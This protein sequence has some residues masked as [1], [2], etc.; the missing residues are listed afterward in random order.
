MQRLD[1]SQLQC[2]QPV[3]ETRKQLQ[4]QPTSP[5]EVLVGD[6]TACANV[7][8]LAAKQG[9]QAQ[10][11]AQN[12]GTFLLHLQPQQAETTAPQTEPGNTAT[13]PAPKAGPT[14]VYLPSTTMGQGSEELGELLMRNFL[15]T[16]AQNSSLPQAILCVNS[17]VKLAVTGS[18]TLEPLQSL[19][20]QGVDIAA[21]GLCLEFFELQD[22]LAIGRATNMVET[23]ETLMQ[24]GHVITP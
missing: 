19:A 24:A 1:L 22:Q 4:Q 11:E 21:C 3:L 9:F 7:A 5:V 8:R 18:P 12:D 6:E 2:P 13:T 10:A 20:D 23:V 15:Y 17:G 14:I 16:L